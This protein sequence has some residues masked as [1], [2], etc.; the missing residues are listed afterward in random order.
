MAT[1]L[2]NSIPD[3]TGG[4][5]KNKGTTASPPALPRREGAGV[6]NTINTC[7]A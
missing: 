6:P 7:E 1:P 4:K 2:W 5:R 3:I